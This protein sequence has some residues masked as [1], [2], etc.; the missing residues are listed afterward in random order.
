MTPA[1]SFRFGSTFSFKDTDEQIC[2][3]RLTCG[4]CFQ[5]GDTMGGFIIFLYFQNSLQCYGF[6]NCKTLSEQRRMNLVLRAGVGWE[7]GDRAQVCSQQPNAIAVS[8]HS[9]SLHNSVR[10]NQPTVAF[11]LLSSVAVVLLHSKFI[12]IY[13][14]LQ[15]F[16]I[17]TVVLINPD[18][19][20]FPAFSD[21]K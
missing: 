7:E 16:L 14:L 9:F 4:D 5:G 20:G 1:A 17:V 8:S 11:S 13:N 21:F 6:L 19:Q 10:G 3:K 15:F 2:T 12:V 18:T